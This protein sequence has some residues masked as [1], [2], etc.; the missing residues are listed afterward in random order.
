M[1]NC[2]KVRVMSD[3]YDD[4]GTQVTQTQTMDYKNECQLCDISKHP[5]ASASKFHIHQSAVAIVIYTP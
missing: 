5:K 1:Q 2:G 3:T 4:W